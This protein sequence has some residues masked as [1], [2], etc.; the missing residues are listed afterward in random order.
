MGGLPLSKRYFGRHPLSPFIDGMA[1]IPAMRE[2]R[3]SPDAAPV[4]RE[5]YRR[6]RALGLGQK[7]LA[8]T[9]GVN[10]TYV[11]DLFHAKSKN[12]KHEQLAKLAQALG[13][14]L[15]DLIHPGWPGEFEEGENTAKTPEEM[16]WLR[17]WRRAS[18]EGRSR[19]TDAIEDALLGDLTSRH[20]AKGS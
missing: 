5:I 7:A 11:R 13:C 6:M 4:A 15:N 2:V 3:L 9:A 12:P 20:K 8:V 19:L 18:L 14:T 17:V 16:A 1:T 10:E